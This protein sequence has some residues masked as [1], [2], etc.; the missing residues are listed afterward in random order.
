MVYVDR[1]VDQEPVRRRI[2]GRDGMSP[3]ERCGKSGE[4]RRAV[5]IVREHEQQC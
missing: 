4:L 2:A 3:E 1:R 5:R